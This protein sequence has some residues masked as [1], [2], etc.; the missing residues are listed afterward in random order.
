MTKLGFLTIFSLK[1]LGLL[2]LLLII[3]TAGAAAKVATALAHKKEEKPQTV[4]FH[5]HKGQDGPYHIGHSAPGAWADRVDKSSAS[6]E[7]LSNSDTSD[8]YNLYEKLL[9]DPYVRSYTHVKR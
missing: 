1:A 2:G 3:N 5:I 7:Y 4:H 9:K 8:R 6:V